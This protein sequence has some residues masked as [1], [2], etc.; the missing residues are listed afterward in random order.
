MYQGS[1]SVEEKSCAQV[2]RENA[3]LIK[4][5]MK[6]QG[7][8][9]RCLVSEG[10]VKSSH[11]HRFYERIE[12]GKLEFDEIVKLRQRLKIDPVRA[13]IAMRC[14]DSPESYEDPCCETTAHVATALA[15]QLFEV[16][17]ACDGEFEPLKKGLCQGLAK[18][19]TTA[20]A[21]NHARIEA[22]REAIGDADRAFG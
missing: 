3:I 10:I 15:V 8:S 12:K 11:R 14:F 20:I 7:V 1:G 13:E 22:Q 19:A 4:L 16:M 18:R 2:H 21:E 5:Q 9:I 6:K 17:A